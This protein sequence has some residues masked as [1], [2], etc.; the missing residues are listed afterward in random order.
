MLLSCRLG[1]GARSLLGHLRLLYSNVSGLAPF[2]DTARSL[3]N[4]AVDSCPACESCCAVHS[5]GLIDGA[6]ASVLAVFYPS[7]RIVGIGLAGQHH[8]RASVVQH[9]SGHKQDFA[10]PVVHGLRQSSSAGR[11][12]VSRSVAL[13]LGVEGPSE[14][15]AW[16]P[17]SVRSFAVGAASDM[18]SACCR[19]A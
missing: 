1:R 9:R 16:A 7:R 15:H 12:S 19:S 3:L 17:R 5:S 18:S 6:L 10:L 4:H 8:R 11:I 2:C 13:Q 14:S